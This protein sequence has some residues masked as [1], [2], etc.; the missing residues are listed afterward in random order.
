MELKVAK[1]DTRDAEVKKFSYKSK[2][3]IWPEGES[4]LDNLINRDSRPLKAYRAVM[5][6]ALD[7]LGISRDGLEIK[8]SRKAG[9]G[10]GCSPGF[11]VDGWNAK[12][13][14]KDLH[15]TVVSA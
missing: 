4:L 13:H 7:S 2:I 6:K 12:L 5:E 9:C 8:W 10:C 14:R 3:Y 1:I 15:V 11:I